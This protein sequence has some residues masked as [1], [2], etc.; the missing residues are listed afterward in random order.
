[1][2]S[3]VGTTHYRASNKKARDKVFATKADFHSPGLIQ[4]QLLESLQG[5]TEYARVYEPGVKRHLVC[6]PVDQSDEKTVYVIE[7]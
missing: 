2:S 3:V 1:M 7:E 6:V 5:V 4:L